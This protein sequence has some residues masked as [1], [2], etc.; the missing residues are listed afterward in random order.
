MTC[1]PDRTRRGHVTSTSWAIELALYVIDAARLPERV[2][3]RSRATCSPCRGVCGRDW[4]VEARR[5]RR[6]SSRWRLWRSSG[7]PRRERVQRGSRRA[8]RGSIPPCAPAGGCLGRGLR[9]WGTTE[10]LGRRGRGGALGGAG[11]SDGPGLSPPRRRTA[12]AGDGA[13][14]D[15]SAAPGGMHDAAGDM[16]GAF[17]GEVAAP[18][19]SMAAGRA[20]RIGG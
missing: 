15:G 13:G 3:R 6:R 2:A 7:S 16:S 9:R 20:A 17:G 5:R 8:R 12:R 10:S 1:R 11:G 18:T 19:R 4:R 14:L